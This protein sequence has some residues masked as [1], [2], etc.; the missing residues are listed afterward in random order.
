MKKRGLTLENAMNITPRFLIN[1]DAGL[2]AGRTTA[3]VRTPVHHG[4]DR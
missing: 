1:D 4:L 2:W 3:R